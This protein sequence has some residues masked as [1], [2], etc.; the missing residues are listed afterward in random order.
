MARNWKVGKDRE[1]KGKREGKKG[2]ERE[3]ENSDHGRRD[4]RNEERKKG[5]YLYLS[6]HIHHSGFW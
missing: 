3:E 6:W 5:G 2:W 4:V 1:R